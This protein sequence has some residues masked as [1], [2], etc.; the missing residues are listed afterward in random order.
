MFFPEKKEELINA[1]K[2]ISLDL[3]AQY[4]IRYQSTND[5][6]KTGFR[7]VEAKFVSKDG[8]K[9][10]LIVPLGYYAGTKSD[11]KSEKKP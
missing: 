9:R 11:P 8:E 6:S 10:K 2:E 5:A 3:R 1:A 4:R 7:R